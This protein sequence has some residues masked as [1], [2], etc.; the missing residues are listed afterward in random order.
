MLPVALVTF[1]LSSFSFVS[2]VVNSDGARRCPSPGGAALVSSSWVRWSAFL[3]KAQLQGDLLPQG[4]KLFAPDGALEA[5]EPGRR[6]CKVLSAKEKFAKEK[7]SRVQTYEDL[8]AKFEE[9]RD[10]LIT[11]FVEPQKS[12]EDQISVAENLLK[13]NKQEDKSFS[14]LQTI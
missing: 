3:L 7:A 13:K 1:L 5:D 6:V 12:C 14:I 10:K 11:R 8:F 4:G 2:E 9:E